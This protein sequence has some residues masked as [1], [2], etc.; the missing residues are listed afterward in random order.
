MSKA[1]LTQSNFKEADFHSSNFTVL[2]MPD[3]VLE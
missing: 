3:S 2:N 1:T